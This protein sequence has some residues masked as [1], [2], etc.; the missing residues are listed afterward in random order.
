MFMGIARD[1]SQRKRT[2]QELGSA[3]R[4]R[5]KIM[6]AIPDLIY[7]IDVGGRFSR[8]N[9]VAEATFGL[10]S[11]ALVG[12]LAVDFFPAWQRE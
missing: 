1:V 9:P 7:A 12:R 3:L 4:E 10:S 8:C 5:R 11:E 6:E 2:E